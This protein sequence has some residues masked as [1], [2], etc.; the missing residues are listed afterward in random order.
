MRGVA[1]AKHE[2]SY[3][4]AKPLYFKVTLPLAVGNNIEIIMKNIDG[5]WLLSESEGNARW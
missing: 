4:R 1:N 2:W 5:T 3:N